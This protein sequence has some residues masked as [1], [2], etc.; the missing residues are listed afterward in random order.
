MHGVGW[1]CGVRV[2]DSFFGAWRDFGVVS[3]YA[4]ASADPCVEISSAV[5]DSELATFQI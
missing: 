3:G 5:N 1:R 2:V 4:A